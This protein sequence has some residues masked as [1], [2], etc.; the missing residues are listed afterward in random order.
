MRQRRGNV[1]L[2]LFLIALGAWLVA[3]GLGFPRPLLGSLWPGIVVVVGLAML[4]QASGLGRRG[5]GLVPLGV[6]IMLTGAFLLLFTLHL[7]GWGEMALYW[8]VFPLIVGLSFFALYV[9]GDMREP[10]LLV[11]SFVVGGLGVILLP[12]TLGVVANPV[13]RRVVWVWPLL[14]LMLGLAF[15]F[16]PGQRGARPSRPP[17]SSRRQRRRPRTR[18]PAPVRRETPLQQAAQPDEPP[19]DEIPAE[20][21]PPAERPDEE[22]PPGEL[23]AEEFP[24]EELPAA[25]TP[26]DEA[27][28]G[29]LPAEDAQE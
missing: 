17:R 9:A 29:E 12:F 26:E 27:N 1:V 2:A 4:A 21:V 20:D 28:G 23:P 7:L 6:G 3:G 8:P 18:P 15:F 16:R 11:P 22:F 5:E 19:A 25:D 10:A 13:L 24:P 14:L